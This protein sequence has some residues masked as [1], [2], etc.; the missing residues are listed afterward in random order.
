MR[1]QCRVMRKQGWVFIAA[2]LGM[3]AGCGGSNPQPI[4]SQD[5]YSHQNISESPLSSADQP[6][7]I[8]PRQGQSLQN[9]IILSPSPQA[10]VNPQMIQ[11]SYPPVG[12]LESSAPSTRP[13]STVLSTTNPSTEPTILATTQASTQA[14]ATAPT[15][16]PGQ[17]MILGTV[18]AVVDGTP[19]YANKVLQRDEP[20]LKELAQQNG[21]PV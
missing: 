5:F 21:L 11:Q 4:Y 8:T 15:I 17:Y 20:M 19:I 13:L 18:V 9:P 7:A 3:L 2:V 6:G 14:A 16:T 12:S 10:S 1:L